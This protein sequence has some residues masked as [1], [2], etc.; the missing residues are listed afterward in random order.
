MS[1]ANTELKKRKKRKIKPECVSSVSET[2]L[3][4]VKPKLRRAQNI[5]T[6]APA[7]SLAS[8]IQSMHRNEAT[9]L[10]ATAWK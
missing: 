6:L 7:H 9:Q 1:S 4:R 8:C 2:G 5:D 3:G 10:G